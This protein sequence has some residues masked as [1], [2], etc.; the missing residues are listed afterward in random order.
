MVASDD[1]VPSHLGFWLGSDNIKDGILVPKYYN[2]E[3]DRAV[4]ALSATCDLVRIGDMEDRGDIAIE[5]GVEPGKMAYGTGKIPFIRTSDLAS[6]ELKI[7]PKHGVSEEIYES[8][9]RNCG[10]EAGDI[11]IVRDGTYLIGTM[12]MVM[13]ADLPMLYQSHLCR[14]RVSEGSSISRWLLFACLNCPLVMRQ[15]RS[16]QFTQDIIDT[17]GKRLL[18][19]RVP[20]PKDPAERK[21]L[22]DETREILETRSAMRERARAVGPSV[23]GISPEEVEEE[24]VDL[25]LGEEGE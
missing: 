16:K 22:E 19:V 2:P 1:V 3:L 4:D 8:Y 23:E 7:D 9:R 13:D 18:E 14:I 15:I 6:W 21:R 12:A 24:G 17:L 20:V 11:L 5:T 25:V 10:V